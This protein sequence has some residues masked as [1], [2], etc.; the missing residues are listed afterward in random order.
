MRAKVEFKR[1]ER[2]IFSQS[3]RKELYVRN[4]VIPKQSHQEMLYSMTSLR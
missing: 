2:K 4:F 1:K 3:V